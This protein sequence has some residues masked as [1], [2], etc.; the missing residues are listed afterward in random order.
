MRS[1]GGNTPCDIEIYRNEV[2][3]KVILN[4]KNITASERWLEK[5][6][7][8]EE[9]RKEF[10][11]ASRATDAID[12]L[13]SVAG[14]PTAQGLISAEGREWPSLDVSDLVMG[15]YRAKLLFLRFVDC[16]DK[17]SDLSWQGNHLLYNMDAKIIIGFGTEAP[18]I[19]GVNW[20][21]AGEG[22]VFIG[23]LELGE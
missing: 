11:Q 17:G 6:M 22:Y 7:K 5:Q 14:P 12:E 21:R 18:P 15:G 16:R 13:V 1:F 20:E 10:E 2:Y 3:R 4:N 9:F 8:D 23:E 19:S